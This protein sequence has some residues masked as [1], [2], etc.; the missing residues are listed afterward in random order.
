MCLMVQRGPFVG[1]R[2]RPLRLRSRERVAE[3]AHSYGAT[4]VSAV[5][6]LDGLRMRQVVIAGTDT[7]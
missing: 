1:K 5:E 3:R 6:I 4:S 2:R 7:F